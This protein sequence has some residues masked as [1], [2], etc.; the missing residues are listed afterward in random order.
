MSV[1]K[2]GELTFVGL[3]VA[4]IA[5]G[6]IQ[7][8]GWPFDAKLFPLAIGYPILAL[9]VFQFVR[10][11]VRTRNSESDLSPEAAYS[12]DLLRELPAEL[13]RSRT[14]VILAWLALSGLL[15]WFL[16]L[17]VGIPMWVFLFLY[18]Q[19]KEALWFS[20][21]LALAAGAVLVGFFD[22]VAHI[23]WP[24]NLFFALTGIESVELAGAVAAVISV[25]V[26]AV[27]AYRRRAQGPATDTE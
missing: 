13:V 27:D 4:L 22:K 10:T 12:D 11:A 9:A 26:V 20:G 3:L 18:L 7:A 25:L 24:G 19:S 17:R 5:A 23:P 8:Q 16:G 2:W 14:G 15:I 6:V 1:R 21:L